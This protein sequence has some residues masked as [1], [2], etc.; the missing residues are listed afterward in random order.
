[1]QTARSWS[2]FRWYGGISERPAPPRKNRRQ[3]EAATGSPTSTPP[4]RS[5]RAARPR[6]SSRP[7]Q[8]LGIDGG[9]LRELRLTN[10]HRPEQQDPT[11]IPIHAWRFRRRQDRSKAVFRSILLPGTTFIGEAP[12][13]PRADGEVW[14]YGTIRLINGNG[15]PRLGRGSSSCGPGMF[16]D[17]S[18]LEL[19]ASSIDASLRPRRPGANVHDSRCSPCGVPPPSAEWGPT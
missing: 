5:R 14:H 16:Q 12:A 9:N 19:R 18:V 17:R 15:P 11:R 13:L 2:V 7:G 1:V 10:R 4:P 8:R 3:I 6:N